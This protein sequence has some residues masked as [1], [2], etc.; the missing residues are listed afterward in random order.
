MNRDPNKAY[1]TVNGQDYTDWTEVR[2]T[3][4]IEA[5]CSDFD[6]RATANRDP[7]KYLNPIG[8]RT[9]AA[10]VVWIGDDKVIT[11]RVEKI[12]VH[13]SPEGR[14]IS[15][16]GRSK[17]RNIVDCCVINSPPKWNGQKMSAIIEEMCNSYNVE[18]RL[19][20]ADYTLSRFRVDSDSK[21]IEAIERLTRLQGFVFTDDPEGGLIITQAGTGYS[22]TALET[23]VNII[24]A[25]IESNIAERFSEYICKGQMAG[26]D[27]TYGADAAEG[28]GT[29][30]DEGL[31]DDDWRVLILKP[32]SKTSAAICKK[33]AEWEAATRL[34]KSLSV[35]ITVHGW[36]QQNGALWEP[37]ISTVV[38]APEYGLTEME[39]L[40]VS[41]EFSVGPEGTL[42]RMKLA[43]ADAYRPQPLT[44]AQLIKI[45]MLPDGKAKGAKGPRA[46]LFGA[47]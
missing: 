13:G 20:G 19:S 45:G 22:L 47:N 43:L 15:I 9:G 2:I 17:T 44:R 18:V 35:D 11:G 38:R 6:F 1:I 46:S 39:L 30:A 24:D 31:D 4:S 5:A 29:A 25:T 26:D 40:I 14:D 42:T 3:R 34:G 36:R 21:V 16:A 10:A 7:E 37:N 28:I 27:M 33:R 41:T 12:G 23:G 8:I 32:E